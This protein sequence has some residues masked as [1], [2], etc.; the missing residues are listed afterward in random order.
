[1]FLRTLALWSVWDTFNDSVATCYGYR[2]CEQGEQK[3]SSQFLGVFFKSVFPPD[4]SASPGWEQQHPQHPLS[5]TLRRRETSWRPRMLLPRV[6][7][8]KTIL[9]ISKKNVYKI[10]NEFIYTINV[11][12]MTVTRDGQATI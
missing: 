8:S 9:N 2:L 12:V 4:S 11:A 10:T 7:W 3:I 5:S 6:W 1:M